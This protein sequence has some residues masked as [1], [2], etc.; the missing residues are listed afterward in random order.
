[1]LTLPPSSTAQDTAL[2]STFIRDSANKITALFNAKSSYQGVNLEA[3]LDGAG[4]ISGE[5]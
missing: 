2:K 3:N 1:M 4:T 5:V